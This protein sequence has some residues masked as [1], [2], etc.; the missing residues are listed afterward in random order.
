[1]A[2]E[3]GFNLT[4]ENIVRL[5]GDKAWRIHRKSIELDEKLAGYVIGLQDIAELERG[6][7][8]TDLEIRKQLEL[9]FP[10]LREERE[11]GEFRHWLWAVRTEEEQDVIDARYLLGEHIP[12]DEVYDRSGSGVAGESYNLYREGAT[13]A[14][15][16]FQETKQAAERRLIE[17][18]KAGQIDLEREWLRDE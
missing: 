9:E 18:D 16:L 17:Q 8:D 3:L 4:I 13:V 7:S 15:E 5:A 2:Q 10:R 6:L 1:M 12:F 11:Q 14:G